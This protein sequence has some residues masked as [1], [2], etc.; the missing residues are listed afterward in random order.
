MQRR[1]ARL[2]PLRVGLAFLIVIG[3]ALRPA[4]AQAM[5]TTA[6]GAPASAAGGGA[7]GGVVVDP[8]TGDATYA[9]PIAVPPGTAG[10]QPNLALIYNSGSRD[11]SWAGVGWTVAVPSVK[12]STRNGVPAN[13]AVF[14]GTGDSFEL[15]GQ[16]LAYDSTAGSVAKYK[17]T[18]QSFLDIQHNNST[19]QWIVTTPDGHRLYFAALVSPDFEWQ[20]VC[21]EDAI[22][23]PCVSGSAGNKINYTYLV[24]NGAAYLQEVTYGQ[25]PQ[26]YVHFFLEARPDQPVSYLAGFLQQL[27]QRLDFI[28]VQT[29]SGAAPSASDIIRRYDLVYSDASGGQSVDSTRSLLRAVTL[30]GVAAGGT[31]LTTKFAYKQNTGAAVGWESTWRAWGGVQGANNSTR[32]VDVYFAQHRRWLHSHPRHSAPR[33]LERHADAVRSLDLGVDRQ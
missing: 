21:E 8:N 27:T 6:S 16:P 11:N 15:D 32:Y 31:G 3:P 4:P 29:V 9:I 30:F 17:T 33:V 19:N 5:G 12:R 23:T 7:A 26:R 13:T 24:D 10:M 28:Q 25:S 22:A 2:V 1:T 20:L 14:N 18:R